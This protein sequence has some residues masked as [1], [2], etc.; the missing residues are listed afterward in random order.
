MADEVSLSV[1]TLSAPPLF[2]GGSG[3]GRPDPT[4]RITPPEVYL[5]LATLLAVIGL[6]LMIGLAIVMG[7]SGARFLDLPS[8]LIVFLGTCAA[9]CIS[10]TGR[11]LR[12]SAPVIGG[13]LVRSIYDPTRMAR[14]LLD[15]AVFARKRG[16]L[17]LTVMTHEL[18]NNPF[19]FDSCQ[20]V[21]DGMS[22]Q[23]I[24][25]LIHQEIDV[26]TERYRK[27]AGIL[28]RASEI[29][30]AMG[31]IGTLIGL[32]QMLSALDDPASI[33]PAMALALLTTFY[34]AVLGSALLSPLAAKLER[35]AHEEALAKS[36]VHATALAIVTQENPRKLEME[37]NSL[38]PADQRI[39]YFD[40]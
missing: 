21:T 11:E 33:G 4:V 39:R 19:L 28:R 12:L 29:A 14:E 22:A 8:V 24:D 23:E 15:L 6:F 7:S 40:F 5:D 27:A 9:T 17:Q 30:P 37:L 35:N 20:M 36:L 1:D 32:V 26:E 16:I 13:V 3:E 2:G 31:L 18:Q 10:Y 25:R 38:L 34:G